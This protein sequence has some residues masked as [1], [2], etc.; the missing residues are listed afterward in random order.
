MMVPSRSGFEYPVRNTL[1]PRPCTSWPRVR[2]RCIL[3]L[4]LLFALGTASDGVAQ[5]GATLLFTAPGENSG[6]RHGFAIA[7]GLDLNGDQI[8]DLAIGANYYS[9]PSPSSRFGRVYLH[10]GGPTVGVTPDRDMTGTIWS[11]FGSALDIAPDLD[12]DG[13]PD[14]VIGAPYAVAETIDSPGRVYV[15]NGGVGL[16]EFPEWTLSG[17]LSFE[18]FGASVAGIGDFNGDG[19]GDLAVGSPL[20]SSE[21]FE[22]GRVSV[23]YGG[24]G[25]DAVADLFSTG[26]STVAAHFGSTVRGLKDFNGDGLGD[27][28]A[29]EPQTETVSLF[30][31][32]ATS[33][34]LIDDLS[35]TLRGYV[36]GAV[37]D[38]NGDGLSDFAIG[39]PGAGGDEGRVEV[40]FGAS[41]PDGT[42]DWILSGNPGEHLGY[43][44][45]SAG[46]VNGD[47]YDDILV[48]GRGS[49]GRLG[50]LYLGGEQPDS[51]PDLFFEAEP[52]TAVAGYRAMTGVGDLDQ[53]GRVDIALGDWLG[54]GATHVFTTDVIV[55]AQRRSMGGIK[56]RFRR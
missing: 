56:G 45:A 2:C 4:C 54:T 31:G 46:D 9:P 53:D 30:L 50:S 14:L 12:G 28:V 38:V 23:F 18:G 39:H 21:V 7:G 34:D 24:P 25:R 51:V 8:P 11:E 10:F 5:P 49:T 1:H 32:S 36:L 55:D 47:G 6:D 37:G 16:D 13:L 33:P 44:I 19:Y 48:G 35:I 20:H 26:T 41:T 42:P 3:P 29:L 22:G 52:G 27:L 17:T 43:S 40:Y 15:Y